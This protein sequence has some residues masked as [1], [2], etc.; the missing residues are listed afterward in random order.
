MKPRYNERYAND[1]TS[2][3][4]CIKQYR[5]FLAEDVEGIS[6]ALFHYRGG[7]EE[8]D[9]ACEYCHSNDAKDRAAGADAMGQLGWQDRTFLQESLDILIP[10]L[11]DEDDYVKYCAAVA[12]GHRNHPDAIP[13]LLKLTNHPDDQVRYG[14]VFG[15]LEH[16]DPRAI[17]ALITLSQD[18]NSEVRNWA[19]FGLGTQ[20]DT[21]SP[22]IRQALISNLTDK[23][24]EIRGE[25]LL[26]LARRGYP[27]ITQELINEWRDN[28]I[29]SL[30]LE[31]AEESADPRLFN[32]LQE[33]ASIF[34]D[35]DDEYFTDRLNCAI[36]ACTPA[37]H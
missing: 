18:K 37:P 24:H 14:V 8:F 3:R 5:K 7:K 35:I 6:L 23:D 30:S 15:L 19:T 4:A 25:A 2:S 9:I 10:M 31:A 20:I 11:K 26:G 16:E 33:L 29:S 12:L 27:N 34:S 28:D 22:E 32:R 21:D 1:P 13:A 36:A 17:I